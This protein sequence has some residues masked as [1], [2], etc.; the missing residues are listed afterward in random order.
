MVEFTPRALKWF[1]HQPRVPAGTEKAVVVDCPEPIRPGATLPQ[2]K[3]VISD[4]GRPASS[5]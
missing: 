4:P 5:P 2:G 1:C 3:N